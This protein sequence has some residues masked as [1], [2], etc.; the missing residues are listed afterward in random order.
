MYEPIQGVKKIAVLR[1]NLLGDL[2][3]TMPAFYA[4]RAAYPEAEIVLLGRHWHL[5]FMSGRPGPVDR[6]E[7]V[8]FISG[9]YEN[10]CGQEDAPEVIEAFFDRMHEQRFDVALQ[11]HGGGRYSNPFVRRLGARLTVGLKTPDSEPL[12]RWVPYVHYHC[13]A[14]RFLEAVALIG[15]APCCVEPAVSVT[16]ADR[17]AAGS[18]LHDFRQPMVV[19]H[20]GASDPRRRWPAEKFAA[21]ADALAADGA[22]VIITGTNAERYLTAAVRAAMI[23]E[24]ID[25]GGMLSLNGLTAVLSFSSL[26]IANDTGPLHLARAVG[27]PTVGIYWVGNV[28]NAGLISAERHRIH[29][30]WRIH[31]PVCNA[32]CIDTDCA[33]RQSFVAE[34][35]PAAVIVSARELLESTSRDNVTDSARWSESRT[36]GA[37]VSR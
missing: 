28:I 36:A 25:A 30:S 11:L 23:R 26:V 10:C 14:F 6:V 7:V 32:S 15:A 1:A 4:V 27:T 5:S 9:I 12:D 16:D 3:M 35:D 21:V 18:F 34:V 33:H 24:A 13:E 22:Q 37:G 31:C 2:M 17:F 8:P 19:I 20:P 29:M